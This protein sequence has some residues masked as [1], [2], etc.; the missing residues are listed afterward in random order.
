MVNKTIEKDDIMKGEYIAK[1]KVIKEDN[2]ESL[3]LQVSI[4]ESLKNLLLSVCVN[5]GDIASYLNESLY[6]GDTDEGSKY[7]KYNRPKVKSFIL[8]ELYTDRKYCL[9]SEDL[10]KNGLLNI[11][12]YSLSLMDEFINNFK[13]NIKTIIDSIN[14]TNI[15]M[16]VTF[17]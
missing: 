10:L 7:L 4:S 5:F 9:F 6:V 3:K 13:N 2:T 14:K 15:D 1:F 12:L 11:E 16:T 8:N 17:N